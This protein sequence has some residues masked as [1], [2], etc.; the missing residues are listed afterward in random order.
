LAGYWTREEAIDKGTFDPEPL[1]PAMDRLRVKVKEG[2]GDDLETEPAGHPTGRSAS[3][4]P[5][6]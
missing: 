3:I 5:D 4:G 1:H 2:E 6:Q